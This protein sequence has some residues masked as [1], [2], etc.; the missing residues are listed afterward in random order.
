VFYRTW[1]T[2]YPNAE[3]GIT[4]EDIQDRWKDRNAPERL[5]RR[6]AEIE[7]NDP[8]QKFIVATDDDK[9]VGVCVATKN[10]DV[11]RLNAIY[12]LPEYQGQGIGRLLWNEVKRFFDPNKDIVVGV[13]TYN[14]DAI[15][16]YTKLGFVDSGHRYTDDRFK[17]KS[18][19]AIPEM[20]MVLVAGDTV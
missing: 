17:M 14:T 12:V 1:L 7:K 3:A 9:V 15:G 8:N 5:A 4:V 11:G 19:T 13:A 20:D 16:F 6:R 2:T 10:D 18:G